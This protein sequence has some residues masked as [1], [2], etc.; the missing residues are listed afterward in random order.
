MVRSSGFLLQNHSQS[1]Y[2]NF[3]IQLTFIEH[4][5]LCIFISLTVFLGV[6]PNFFISK[7]VFILENVNN[8]TYMYVPFDPEPK[9]SYVYR[10]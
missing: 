8:T 6:C 3:K 5:V 7:L 10:I 9:Y 1:Y 4:F 2:L